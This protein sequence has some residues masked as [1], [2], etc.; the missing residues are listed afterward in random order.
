MAV[1]AKLFRSVKPSIPMFPS[2]VN[3][4]FELAC[5]ED[6]S[7]E[8]WFEENVS[9]FAM[10]VDLERLRRFRGRY[11]FA[12]GK[13]EQLPFADESFDFVFSRLAI[14][15]MDIPVMLKE[16][17]RV[18]KLGGTVWFSLHDI[19]YALRKIGSDA[20]RFH[21]PSVVYQLY[22]IAN[23]ISL[24]TLGKLYRYNGYTGSVQTVSGMAKVLTR[25]GFTDIKF[26]GDGEKILAM[27]AEKIRFP[28][29]PLLPRL[30][31]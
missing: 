2:S 27:S 3:T 9:V 28:D 17:H 13:G 6:R 29:S 18:L 1:K 21:F 26:G 12:C 5:G 24:H 10:D 4:V 11:N 7:S 31:L 19:R 15:Y 16:V 25:S 14:P 22:T 20:L 30:C 8:K 23:G